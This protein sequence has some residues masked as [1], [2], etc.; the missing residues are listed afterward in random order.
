MV[1]DACTP[2]LFNACTSGGNRGTRFASMDSDADLRSADMDIMLL[3]HL[4]QAQGIAGSTDQHG[5]AKIQDGVQT[6]QRIQ[7][8]TGD[9]ERTQAFRAFM[10]APEAD[11][12]SKA[13]GQEDDIVPTDICCPV[14]GLQDRKSTR[15]N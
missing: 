13:K 7:A 2:G 11:K 9:G 14:D 8:A 12:G 1:I 4:C 6:L 10:S 5:R 3:R 15:L